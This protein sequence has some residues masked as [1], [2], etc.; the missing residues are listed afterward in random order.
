MP[1]IKP[2]DALNNVAAACRAYKGN[3]DEH[4][5]LQKSL[6]VLASFLPKEPQVLPKEEKE[7][8]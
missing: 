6:E 5:V 1:E 4:N 3:I 7:S 8:A 2:N